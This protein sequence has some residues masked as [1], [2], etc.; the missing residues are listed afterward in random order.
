MEKQKILVIDDDKNIR[1]ILSDILK[2]KGYEPLTVDNGTEALKLVKQFSPAL[3][4]LDLGLPDMSGLD[5]LNKVKEDYPSTEAIILTGNASL[6]SAIEATNKG[7]FSYLLKPY[8]IDQLMLHIRHALQKREAEEALNRSEMY[9]RSLIENSSDIITILDASGIISYASPS[10]EHVVGFTPEKLIGSKIFDIIHQ[11]DLA[12]A[13]NIFSRIMQSPGITLS[14][15]LRLRHNDGFWHTH[16]VAVQNLLENEAVRGMVINSHDITARRK[17]E[18]DLIRERN[19]LTNLL[20]LY[21]FSDTK[22]KDIESSVIEESIE[23][24]GSR[25][26]FFGFINEDE[27]L[28]N[29]HLWSEKATE[30]CAMDYKPMEFILADAGIWAEA[31]RE[32]KP[33]IMNDYSQP[34]PRKKG[35]PEGHVKIK[36]LLGIPLVKEGKAL[37][38]VIV[39]NKEQDYNETDLVHLSLYLESVWDI[40]KRRQAEE[41]AQELAKRLSTVIDF[42]P[43]ATFAVDPAGKVIVWNR[44]IEEMTGVKADNI[45]GKGDY[46]YALPFYGVRRPILIDLVFEF[47]EENK[48][49]YNFVRKENDVF[50]AETGVNLKGAPHA[51]WGKAG[52]LYDS[53]G[54]VVGAIESIRDIT[55]FKRAEDELAWKTALLEAQM[56]ASMDGIMVVDGKGKQILANNNLFD[57]LDIPRHL[58]DENDD[59]T[60]LQ[61]AINKARYPERF[62]TRVRHFYEHPNETGIDEIEFKDGKV[63]DRYS[64]PVLGKNGEYYG[65]IW[66]FRDITERKK[67]QAELQKKNKELAE[68]CEELRKR[69]AMVVQQEKMASI[70]ML[71]SGIAHEIKN[72][73]A[74]ILQGIDYMR[75]KVADDASMVEA[76]EKMNNAILRAD[77]IVKGLVS[78]SRRTPLSLSEHDISSLLDEALILTDHEFRRKNLQLLRQYAPDLPKVSVDG[79]Q[80]KQVFLNVLLNGIDAMSPKG[81]FTI[82]TQQIKN[83]EGK[84]VVQ[85]SFKDTGKG[86]PANKIHKIFDPFYT[87]KSVGN[88][89]LG[90]SVSK[91]IIDCHRGVIYAASQE[92]KGANIIIELP[93]L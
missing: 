60:L 71:A 11:D 14:A 69:Q 82:S 25:L 34:D 1:K 45:L 65:R 52:P 68:A 55:E 28:M 92:E 40:F 17:A 23:I 35:Y 74:I 24:T 46:E 2:M 54:N 85:I 75:A 76:I 41:E 50:L 66:T 80:I 62:H 84:K 4:I 93:V 44:A 70:G 42:L 43:D 8:E 32:H 27:T 33:L 61:H 88:T 81:T 12:V 91:G 7:A 37:A 64:S 20:S 58:H 73:L 16:E 59:T 26:G 51:L 67:T 36:R 57:I 29:I 63:L 21:R 83:A 9:F 30:G 13:T 87:T 79:N 89:G 31:I 49:K 5:V 72:P 77:E 86:I 22:M 47:S 90:L 78:Y 10:L 3:V 15:E 6:D 38:A 19:H 18:E 48:K 56:E 53:R 39:A